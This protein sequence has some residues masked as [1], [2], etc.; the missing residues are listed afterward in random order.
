MSPGAG[1][2]SSF[3]LDRTVFP[4]HVGKTCF[5]RIECAGTKPLAQLDLLVCWI[6][7]FVFVSDHS[8]DVFLVEVLARWE[9]SVL[10]FKL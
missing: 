7:L 6:Y 3:L 2:K 10:S 4:E 8:V 1:G 5:L 9:G